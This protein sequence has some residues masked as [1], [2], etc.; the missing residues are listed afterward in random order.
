MIEVYDKPGLI[1]LCND[2]AIKYSDRSVEYDS[3]RGESLSAKVL[4]LIDWHRRRRRMAD[5]VR[6]V[7]ADFKFLAEELA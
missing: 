6:K 1:A 3:L 2:L 5:L 7:L 4:Y